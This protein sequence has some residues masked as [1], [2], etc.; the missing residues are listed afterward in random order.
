MGRLEGL[1]ETGHTTRQRRGPSAIWEFGY[2]IGILGTV[3]AILGT[4]V[5]VSTERLAISSR[6]SRFVPTVLKSYF[7]RE[8]NVEEPPDLAKAAADA[9]RKL[10]P[11]EQRVRTRAVDVF[12]LGDSEETVLTLQ[13]RPGRK[14]GN[15]WYYGHSSVTFVG[16]RVVSWTN[17]SARPL[18]VRQ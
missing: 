1:N 7:E 11:Q 12:G 17:S 5:I 9:F 18:R 14:H 6:I 10:A 3:V 15:V 4:A 16:G 8:S 2:S 13:G